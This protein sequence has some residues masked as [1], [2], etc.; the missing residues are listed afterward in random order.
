M[1]TKRTSYVYVLR[2]CDAKMQGHGGFQ[3]PTKGNVEAP[4]WN[5]KAQCGHGLHGW[6]WGEGD[7]SIGNWDKGHRVLVVKVRSD[8]IVGL[9]GKVKFP[10]GQVVYCGDASGATAFLHKKLPKSK[11][12]DW[13]CI[14][15]TVS[16]GDRSTVS[17]GDLSTV[18]GGYRSTVSGGDLSTVSG[19]DLST[20]S[21]GE[22]GIIVVRWHDGKRYRLAVGYVGE[23]GIKKG[24]LYHVVDGKLVEGEDADTKGAREYAAKISA[25]KPEDRP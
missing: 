5:A 24:V 9:G 2:T 17:G 23:G 11:M 7:G 18:S 13:K 22:D 21:G 25:M 10:R 8:K 4:D 6:L 20:V 19:G 1:P 16:G 12:G 15:R 14:A 3:W